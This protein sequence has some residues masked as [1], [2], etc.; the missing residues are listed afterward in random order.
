VRKEIG[1]LLMEDANGSVAVQLFAETA[2]VE[3]AFDDL[4]GHPGDPQRRAT[5]LTLKYGD[6]GKVVDARSRSRIIPIIEPVESRP[7]GFVLGEGPVVF[8]KE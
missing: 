2:G 4:N 6:D 1:V 5:L 3:K 8:P 7:D